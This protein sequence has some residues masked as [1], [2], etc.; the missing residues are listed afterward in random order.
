MAAQLGFVLVY[1]ADRV[2][3]AGDPAV[4]FTKGFPL[5]PKKIAYLQLFIYKYIY[6][7]MYLDMQYQ[8]I[9]ILTTLFPL[10]G[11]KHQTPQYIS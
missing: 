11:E 6:I 1:Q 5:C 3:G 9:F 4:V 2:E 10:L 7:Y 8:S